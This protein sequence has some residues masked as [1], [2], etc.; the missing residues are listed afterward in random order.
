MVVDLLF[1]PLFL[2]FGKAK[3][4]YHDHRLP[5]VEAKFFLYIH[6]GPCPEDRVLNFD[7]F[8]FREREFPFAKK[9]AIGNAIAVDSPIPPPPKEG[10]RSTKRYCEAEHTE[11]DDQCAFDPPNR[12]SRR[13]PRGRS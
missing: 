7:K 1:Q 10:E 9:V 12:R 3:G 5:F 11:P 8:D 6:E 2:R 13:R 4:R